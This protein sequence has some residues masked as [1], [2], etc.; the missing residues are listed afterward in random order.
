LSSS[1]NFG[2]STTE[3][4]PSLQTVG[5]YPP[6]L[7]FLDQET[8]R[9]MHR[10]WT[11]RLILTSGL[12][13]SLAQAQQSCVNGIRVDGTI[14]DPTGAVITGAQVRATNGET[15]TTDTVGH[16]ILP[17]ISADAVTLAV[18]ADGFAQGT[19]QAR[20]RRGGNAH[21][22]LQLAVAAVETDVQ[23]GVDAM[24]MDADHGMGT[25]TL[26]AE[27][28][29]QLPDDPD[30]F[31]RELQML[32]SVSGGDPTSAMI[33]V[34]GFQ[35]GSMLPPKGS[36][37]SIRISPDFFSAEYRFPP[38]NGGQIEIMTKPGADRYHGAL[39][40]TDSNGS[41]NAT[42]PFSLTA[43][44]AS[45]QRYGFEF[46]GPIISKKSGFAL[47]LEKRDINEFN[48]VNAVTLNAENAP[49]ALQQTISAPQHLWIGSARA[50]WQAAAN[51]IASISFSA[52][53]NNIANQG[54][55]GLSLAESGYASTV[56]QYDLHLMN[57]QTLNDHALHST[58]IGYSWK[59]TE[60]TPLS[61]AP[62]LQV[63]GYFT[64]GGSTGG[65][66]NDRERDLE[67][68]DDF[69]YT[70]GKHE[71]KVG[72]QSL[73][74]F[75]H[76][77]DPNTFNG[78]YVFGGG[79][80][81]VLNSN[82]NPTS[83]TET[84]TPIEQYRRALLNLA[85]G[86]PTTYQLT[87]GTP[88]VPLTQWRLGLYA[89][90]SIKLAP[91]V[92]LSYG[93]R[94]AFQ[95]TPS[96]FSNFGP[97]LGIGWAVD[98]KQ[99]W[100]FHLRAGLFNNSPTNPPFAVEVYRLNGIRQQQ[101]TIYSPNYTNPLTPALGSI[102]ISTVNQFPRSS[103]S[104]TSTFASYFTAEHEFPHQWHASTDAYWGE[105]YNRVRI[106]NINAP[107]VTS[108]V[109][110]PADPTAALL[111]PRPIAP[112]ENIFQ[113]ENSG[114][115]GGEAVSASLSQHSYKRF[116]FSVWY[117]YK[118]FKGD[119]GNE[120][121]PSPQSSY[122]NQG[123]SARA[124]WLRPDSGGMVGNLVLP[125]GF[126]LAGQF[127][128]SSGH[129]YNI[130]T[131]TDNNGDGDFNDRPAYA[132]APGPGVYGT[133]HG[134]LTTNTVNGTIPR[135]LGTMPATTHLDMNLSRSFTLNPKDNDHPRTLTLNARS[136]NLLNHTNVTAVN[137]I[138]SSGS[139]G[140]PLT[141][142]PARRVELGIRFAF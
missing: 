24:A 13:A 76:D 46:S 62:A 102:Q 56:G 32:A 124:D 116:G 29:Q 90:D 106:R 107:M 11:Y 113:Y 141:A 41:F 110:A 44:P 9:P 119:G 128:A 52:N 72:A 33:R 114:H 10:S 121:E 50:D 48:V 91:R 54:S 17:C 40:F 135:N 79:S 132:S 129:P 63:A 96:S 103:L 142:E 35:N 5:L 26:N 136:A 42:D 138:V 98:K 95:T 93:L 28:V 133:R 89:Q 37:A 65:N 112:N 74:I 66:L 68:D 125:F 59:R 14:T 131:G 61:S 43:T 139:L 47:A 86:A 88:L 126:Q 100:V 75:I 94:Y 130:T 23:V 6:P 70:H 78:S 84:I 77:F 134:L 81:P 7:S 87:A 31:L 85:G 97:R 73:G 20:S 122:S 36:I 19:V 53:V 99:T 15:A 111:A 12:V 16:Y 101:V 2:L 18:R 27:E 69:L 25:I 104:Q 137:T 3:F 82:N 92:T 57:S 21:V 55:G 71:V 49:A 45:K 123:E 8:K 1:Q 34:D 120:P 115:L 39:F 108:S 51:D 60:Q 109:G 4:A 67:I 30:D 22:N 83:Q 38:F 80:A 105:D 58:R 117:S 140:Q 127:D 64:D 118:H